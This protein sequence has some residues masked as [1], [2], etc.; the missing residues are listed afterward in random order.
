[1]VLPADADGGEDVAGNEEQQEDVM[2]F[3]VPQGVEDGEEDQAHGAHEREGHAQPAE[4]LLGAAGVL[5]QAAA[6]PQ[7][8]LGHEGNVEE[9][10]RHT[11]AGDEERFERLGAHVRDVGDGLPRVHGSVSWFLP[12]G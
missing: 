4:D 6:V 10:G 7:P 9:D 5:H 8:S 2:E 3:V 12:A 11:C 1:L